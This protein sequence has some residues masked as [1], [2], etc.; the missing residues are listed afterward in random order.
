MLPRLAL[1]FTSRV[2]ISAAR[3]VHWSYW[4]IWSFHSWATRGMKITMPKT[5]MRKMVRRSRLRLALRSFFL[6]L[7]LR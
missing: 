7:F 1:T 4:T 5:L 2:W 6:A 3:S